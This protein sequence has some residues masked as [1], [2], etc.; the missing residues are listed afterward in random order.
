[1]WYSSQLKKSFSYME[2][3][4]SKEDSERFSYLIQEGSGKILLLNPRD[5]RKDFLT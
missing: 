2:I 4:R 1:M 5:I 3:K